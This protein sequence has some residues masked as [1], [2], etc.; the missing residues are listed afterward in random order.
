MKIVDTEMFEIAQITARKALGTGSELY[1]F[2]A[3]EYLAMAYGL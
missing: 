3:K 1:W 2:M